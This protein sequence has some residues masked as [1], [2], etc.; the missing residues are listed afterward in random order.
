[1]MIDS[2]LNEKYTLQD[3]FNRR[4][5]RSFAQKI[6]QAVKNVKLSNIKNQLNIMYNVM[7]LKLWRNIKRSNNQITLNSFMSDINDCKHE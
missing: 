1:M 6:I 7:N 4:E 5:S 2:M 3:A